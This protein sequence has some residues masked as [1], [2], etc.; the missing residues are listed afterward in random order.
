[1]TVQ[2]E[3]PDQSWIIEKFGDF[4]YNIHMEECAELIQAINKYIRLRDIESREHVIEE[5]V[6]VLICIEQLRIMLDITDTELQSEIDWKYERTQ[7]RLG[8]DEK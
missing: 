8:I 6:D 2:Y 5:M 3:I 4:Q 1:M 7:R